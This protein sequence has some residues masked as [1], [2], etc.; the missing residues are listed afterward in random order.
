MRRILRAN[1]SVAT[2]KKDLCDLLKFMAVLRLE[3]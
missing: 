1:K 3:I 2:L